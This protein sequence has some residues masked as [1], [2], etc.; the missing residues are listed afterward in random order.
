MSG[1]RV[2]AKIG[3]HLGA[4]HVTPRSVARRVS[5]YDLLIDN[6]KILGIG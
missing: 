3:C 2:D 6:G 4:T 1:G 5:Q